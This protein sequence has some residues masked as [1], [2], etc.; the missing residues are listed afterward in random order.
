MQELDKLEKTMNV[1]AC[2]ALL[3]KKDGPKK[4]TRKPNKYTFTIKVVE[5]EDLKACDPSGYSDP[6]VVFGDEYQKR[7]HKTRI[8]HRNLNPRWDESF[9]ITV[10]GPVNVI[11]TIWDY[12]TFGDHDYVGRTSLK[13]DP[14]HFGDYLPREFWL[15]LDSQGRLLIRVSMEGERDDIVFHFGKAFRHLKRTE[16][17]MVRKITDKVCCVSMCYVYQDSG[18][19]IQ[20]QLTVQINETLSLETLRGLLGSGGVGASITSLWKKRTSTNTPSTG[21]TQAQIESAL[22]NLFSY[23]DDNF[24]IMKM[25]LTDATMIAVMTRLWKD[26][27]MTIENLLVPP[28]SEKPSTQKPLSR[29][30]LDIVY[31][32]LEMLF[33][34][35]NAKDEHSGEQ[36]GVPAEVLKSPKWHELA[37]LNFFYFE[38][39]SNLIRES[40][41]MAAASAQRAQQALQQQNQPQSQSSNRLAVPSSLGASLGGAGSFASMGTIRRGKSIMMSRNLGT[42]RKAKEAKRREMQ[43]DASDD[44][45]LR[46]LRMRPE[47]ANYLKERQRQKERQAATAAAALIVKNSV[48]QGWNSGV[49]A[50]SGAPFG[51]NSLLPNRR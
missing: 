17:D 47:A 46:I 8:I 45:I 33:V 40:E 25:T 49:P 15:D 30:E 5:A 41:R 7:L 22:T 34:F 1:E 12:D 6:Y 51:R 48:S 18:R 31:H 44:M 20:L 39:T 27:L 29:R 4:K 37:S 50:F 24:A 36:L 19:L 10:Q 42:M 43:A 23:F 9:D 11:A 16:R 3:E 35:F 2:A 28:L 14:N 13:L 38:D 32:W 21:P 26:V